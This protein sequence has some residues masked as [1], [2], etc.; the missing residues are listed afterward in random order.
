MKGYQGVSYD[1]GD[2]FGGANADC[3]ADIRLDE[4]V[5]ERHLVKESAVIAADIN[6]CIRGEKRGQVGGYG[7]GVLS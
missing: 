1:N 3:D 7:I 6:A 4:R 5:S 2:I